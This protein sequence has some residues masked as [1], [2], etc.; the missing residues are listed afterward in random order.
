MKSKPS[1]GNGRKLS[2]SG[3]QG[4]ERLA[5]PEPEVLRMI[6]EESRRRGT[7]RITSREVGNII[8]AVRRSR[9][10]RKGLR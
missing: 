10:N 8:G 9:R 4:Y 6:G 7:D 2:L 3:I 5:A 1:K